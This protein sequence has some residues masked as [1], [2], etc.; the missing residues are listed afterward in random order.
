MKI[1]QE[2]ACH[3]ILT[4]W[5]STSTIDF[6]HGLTLS[7]APIKFINLLLS[8]SIQKM[9]DTLGAKLTYV[10]NNLVVKMSYIPNNIKHILQSLYLKTSLQQID[11]G[12]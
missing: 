4:Y 3:L 9:M 11:Y 12:V 5:C 7:F 8:A 6:T 1:Y 2:K 10:H